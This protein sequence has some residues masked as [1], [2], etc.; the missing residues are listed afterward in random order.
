MLE[1]LSY[2]L[3]EEDKVVIQFETKEEELVQILR[4]SAL[5]KLETIKD[6]F[7]DDAMQ[8][9]RAQMIDEIQVF[10]KQ[11]FRIFDILFSVFVA[12]C[13]LLVTFGVFYWIR[14]LQSLII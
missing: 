11:L 12:V 6:I 10:A 1:V 7:I 4:D 8:W 13:F 14:R 5:T 2:I 9:Q 3:R